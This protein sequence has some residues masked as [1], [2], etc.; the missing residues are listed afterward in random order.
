VTAS[1]TCSAATVRAVIGGAG[2][3][4]LHERGLLEV[5]GSERMRWLDGMVTASV[6]TLAPGDGAHA[7]AL[8]QQGRI[9]AD[10]HL[11][12]EEDRI[13]ADL[14]REAVEP[15][16]SH[17]DARIIA[18][19]VTLR[20]ASDDGVHLALEG[21]QAMAVL[22]RAGAA[23]PELAPGAFAVLELAGVAFTVAAYGF[24]GL[25]A[26]QLFVPA[27]GVE[28]VARTLIDAGATDAS[29]EVL[30]C[31][32]IAAGTPR[33]G[34]DID[35]SVLPAEARLEGA[36]STTKGC[37][38]GQEVVARMSSR[39]RVSHLLVGL[40]FDGPPP[41]ADALLLADTRE[42][43]EVTSVFDSPVHGP[44]GLGYVR[45]DREAPGTRLRAD[46]REAE[47]VALPHPQRPTPP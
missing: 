24:S 30:E 15:L 21:P 2:L 1:D 43:G 40:A 32:R 9:V 29:P 45:A 41:P 23:P 6:A 17:L 38:T 5:M 28:A 7:L 35:E 13:V 37:Y 25:P 8:T 34:H 11:R 12:V 18:D 26:L 46:G 47:V 39:G 33:F 4:H 31:L 42:V 20:D 10:L 3:F 44:I 19:D 14:E 22:E 16:Q 36:I 27:S